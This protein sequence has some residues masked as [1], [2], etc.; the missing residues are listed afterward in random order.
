MKT[1]IKATS[2]AA[3]TKLLTEIGFN[4]AKT[5]K[6]SAKSEYYPTFFIDG[7]N[8]KKAYFLPAILL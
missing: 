1:I 8:E 6:Y 4:K 7:V 3:I 5:T 2:P